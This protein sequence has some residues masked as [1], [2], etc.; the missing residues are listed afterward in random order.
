MTKTVWIIIGVAVIV[1]LVVVF[2][3]RGNA[4]KREAELQAQ[5]VA[6]QT[7][8]QG[9]GK[10]KFMDFLGT[11]LPTILASKKPKTQAQID[12]CLRLAG[13]NEAKRLECLKG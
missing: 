8:G 10:T 11:I 9:P 12:L 1:L 13:D 3:M 4:A 7:G 6:Q 5:F 2:I